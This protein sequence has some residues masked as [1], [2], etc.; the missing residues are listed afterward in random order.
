[1]PE[2]PPPSPQPTT[3]PEE[4][5]EAINGAEEPRPA[6]APSAEDSSP[7]S[8]KPSASRTPFVSDPGTPFDPEA[9]PPPPEVE[10]EPT[11][12]EQ[13]LEIEWE[14]EAVRRWLVL[15]GELTHSFIGVAEIDW[16]HTEADLVSIAGPL[17]RILNRYDTT[18]AIAAYNDPASVIFGM[19][20]YTIRSFNERR[21]VIAAMQEEVPITGVAAPPGSGPPDAAAGGE[22]LDWQKD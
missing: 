8:R 10:V 2:T 1:M 19:S 7:A 14:E 3:T 6:A 12:A 22:D 4:A 18:R 9:A 20:M 21:A 11:A 13:L 17:A 15:Q 5:E 16:K